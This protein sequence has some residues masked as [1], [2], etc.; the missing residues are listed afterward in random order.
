MVTQYELTLSVHIC[1]KHQQALCRIWDH[2][3]LPRPLSWQTGDTEITEPA[4]AVPCAPATSP[5]R[6]HV[7]P[8]PNSHQ[9][10]TRI[11]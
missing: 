4:E 6:H 2:P 8:M 5:E 11:L 7:E 3:F 1:S 9:I 10:G